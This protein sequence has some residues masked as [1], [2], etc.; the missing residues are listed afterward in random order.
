VISAADQ[1]IKKSKNDKVTAYLGNMYLAKGMANFNLKEFDS[2]LEAFTQA[3]EL[4][5]IKK[6]AIQWAKYV[7]REQEVFERQQEVRL[8]M[9]N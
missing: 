8:A 7:E 6:T 9:L 1:A 3:Q 4:P 5:K 2:A